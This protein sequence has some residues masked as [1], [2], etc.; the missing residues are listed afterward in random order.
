MLFKSST[1]ALRC[2]CYTHTREREREAE[3]E[4][5]AAYGAEGRRV[6]VSGR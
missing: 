3:E 5:A 4:M 6:A 1:I 2:A